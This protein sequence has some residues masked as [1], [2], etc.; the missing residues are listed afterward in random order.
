MFG[1]VDRLSMEMHK[2]LLYLLRCLYLCKILDEQQ[3]KTQVLI[4]CFLRAPL[5]IMAVQKIYYCS[6]ASKSFCCTGSCKVDWQGEHCVLLY[7]LLRSGL[8]P[9]VNSFVM[10]GACAF[11][12]SFL[13]YLSL[14]VC[15]ICLN[16]TCGRESSRCVKEFFFIVKIFR[17]R[18]E[19]TYCI[20]R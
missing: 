11:I 10:A 1:F 14:K 6:Q 18:E 2:R 5:V 13:T 16:F 7:S 15:L 9:H 4:V 20:L 12:K 8:V 17:I 3:L 19:I